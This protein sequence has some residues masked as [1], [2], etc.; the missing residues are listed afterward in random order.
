MADVKRKKKGAAKRKA[1]S[2]KTKQQVKDR[3][4]AVAAVASEKKLTRKDANILAA[5]AAVPRSKTKQTENE[6]DEIKLAGT[7]APPKKKTSRRLPSA[8]KI[9]RDI[10]FVLMDLMASSASDAVRVAAA[11]ALMDKVNKEQGDETDEQERRSKERDDALAEA[12]R[13]L[14]ELAALKSFGARHKAKV[15]V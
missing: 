11:K 5:E 13:L 2:K 1:L 14:A 9:E 7:A 3:K 12:G 8:A 15:A 6:A 10:R 4:E